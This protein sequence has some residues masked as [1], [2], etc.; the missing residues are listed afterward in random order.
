MADTSTNKKTVLIVEDEDIVARM[1]QAGL[2]N[3]SFAIQIA[4]NGAEALEVMKKVKPAIVL[5]DIMM[6][7]MNGIQVLET[8]KADPSLKDIHVIMMSN[9]SSDSDKKMA[10]DKGANDYWVKR[11]VQPRELEKRVVEI[12]AK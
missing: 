12:L 4:R 1:Y 5:L 6:P 11:D 7:K 8:M 2:A 10:M 3:S 9:L